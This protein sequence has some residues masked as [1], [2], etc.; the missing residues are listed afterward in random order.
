MSFSILRTS[1]GLVVYV[2][3]IWAS[4]TP[5]TVILSTTALSR[6]QSTACTTTRGS[7][8]YGRCRW[9]GTWPRVKS[10]F[11]TTATRKSF[12]VRRRPSGPSITLAVGSP[13]RRTK[14]SGETSN[15]TSDTSGTLSNN[16][17]PSCRYWRLFC[18]S[19]IVD[20]AGRLFWYAYATSRTLWTLR[21]PVFLFLCTK[22]CDFDAWIR[23]DQGIS[24]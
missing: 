4:T 1:F 20:V 19:F 7:E 5:P 9:N 24:G 17:S 3:G 6:T 10:C 22:T 16:T 14:T 18:P 12:C 23:G 15:T 8:R 11:A 21:Y 13:T 2:V